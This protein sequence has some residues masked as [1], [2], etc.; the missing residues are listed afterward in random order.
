M[1][2][3]PTEGGGKISAIENT[4]VNFFPR[5]VFSRKFFATEIR[6]MRL[7]ECGRQ[8]TIDHSCGKQAATAV[9][10]HQRGAL[11]QF[12]AASIRPR[13]PATWTPWGGVEPPGLSS[14][15]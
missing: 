2:S 6:F 7:E 5:L 8:L 11:G 15:C 13:S 14:R 3:V 4:L 1:F 12:V 9:S 10:P